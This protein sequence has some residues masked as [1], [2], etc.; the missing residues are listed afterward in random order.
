MGVTLLRFSGG[1][2]EFV[3]VG[4]SGNRVRIYFCPTCGSTIYWKPDALPSMIGVAVGALVAPQH[5]A[6]LPTIDLP[7]ARSYSSRGPAASV[8]WP[9]VQ[10]SLP[11]ACGIHWLGS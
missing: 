2:T 8:V 9:R 5:L 1:A 4:D 10:S 11:P 6:V 7:V 3:H